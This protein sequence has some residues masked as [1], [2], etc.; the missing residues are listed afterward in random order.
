ML[1]FTA[2]KTQLRYDVESGGELSALGSDAGK[3]GGEKKKKKK[4]NVDITL[5]KPGIQINIFLISS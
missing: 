1:I 5:D 3:S 2:K 4:G